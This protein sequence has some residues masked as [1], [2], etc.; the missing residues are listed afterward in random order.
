MVWCAD[1]GTDAGQ[2]ILVEGDSLL[3]DALANPHVRVVGVVVVRVE[4]IRPRVR[5]Q[6]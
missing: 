3:H 4:L 1:M 5:S 2:I 6:L